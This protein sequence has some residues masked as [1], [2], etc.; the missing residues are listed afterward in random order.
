MRRRYLLHHLHAYDASRLTVDHLTNLSRGAT[1][2]FLKEWVHRSVQ[3]ATERLAGAHQSPELREADFD[4]ALSEM[5]RFSEGTT[6]RIV[7]FLEG[8][9]THAR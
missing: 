6:G 4:A 1:Q 3:I 7:G 5:R 2:A 9:H 8:S